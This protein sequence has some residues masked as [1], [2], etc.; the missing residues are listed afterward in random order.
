MSIDTTSDS[1]GRHSIDMTGPKASVAHAKSPERPIAG[2]SLSELNQEVL[3]DSPKR[4][5][6]YY[7]SGVL[8]TPDLLGY[9]ELKD[10]KLQP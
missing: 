3:L 6:G 9:P 1:L 10:M 8:V 2:F 5:G 7:W 4:P